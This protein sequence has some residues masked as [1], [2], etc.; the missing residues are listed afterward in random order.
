MIFVGM[1]V[2]CKTTTMCLLDPSLPEDRQHRVVTCETTSAAIQGVLAPLKGECKVAFEVGTQSQ[3]IAGMV[4]PLAREVQVA[5]PSQVPWLFRDGRK[6]DRIDARKLAVL[7]YMD[8]LPQVHLPSREVSAWRSLINYRRA[9]VHQRT[10]IKIR[11]RTILRSLGLRYL[12]RGTVW[13]RV[14]MIWLEMAVSDNAVQRLMM[15]SLVT[16]LQ[17]KNEQILAVE[18]ELEKIAR[19]YPAV[20]LLQTIPGIG[21]RTSEA[22]VAYTDEIRRFSRSRKF[23]SYFGLTPTEDS[24]AG[25]V[26]Y[27]HI[28]KRGPSVVRWV[29]GE[30]THQVIKYCP[31]LRAF[32]DRLHRGQ[33]DRKKK[34]IVG[35]ARK[36]LT[37]MFRMLRDGTVFDP[38]RIGPDGL[39]EK[40]A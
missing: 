4:R 11:I 1:D 29:L 15:Q 38:S 35:T 39:G 12:G 16:E 10:A 26:R 14:G 36:V 18:Q 34:A 37:V 13:S 32:F 25:V 5:N 2:H 31:E 8:Q 27:G 23:A 9:L 3:L 6:N 28:S 33:K 21:P 20:A 7:L 40:V 22:V 19:Q 24:S 17:A 30:A